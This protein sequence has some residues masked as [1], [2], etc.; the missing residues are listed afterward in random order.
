MNNTVLNKNSKTLSCITFKVN[1]L[2]SKFNRKIQT[3]TI[4]KSN[5][6][7]KLDKD[8]A[9]MLNDL[10]TLSSCP[11][12]IINK[13]KQYGGDDFNKLIEFNE[14]LNELWA[15]VNS[16]E[17]LF[18]HIN[19]NINVKNTIIKK[20][21]GILEKHEYILLDLASKS[22]NSKVYGEETFNIYDIDKDG[23]ITQSEFNK[24]KTY[25]QIN[26]NNDDKIS[27]DEFKK[28]K[29]VISNIGEEYMKLKDNKTY[30]ITDLVILEKL[31]MICHNNFREI[32][33]L[34]EKINKDNLDEVYEQCLSHIKT[35]K[36]L[37]YTFNIKRSISTPKNNKNTNE[38]DE[39]EEELRNFKEMPQEESYISSLFE[40]NEDAEYGGY[41]EDGEDKKE[42]AI[43]SIECP[44]LCK[45]ESMVSSCLDVLN[46][47]KHKTVLHQLISDYNRV[48]KPYK[49]KLAN[50]S[51]K[52]VDIRHNFSVFLTTHGI[53]S[54]EELPYTFDKSIDYYGDVKKIF[55][56]VHS[57]NEFNNF[58]KMYNGILEKLK[59][60][61]NPSINV[62]IK[63]YDINKELYMDIDNN[64]DPIMYKEIIELKSKYSNSKEAK[65]HLK[66]I[67]H[68]ILRYWCLIGIGEMLF[69]SEYEELLE[70]LDKLKEKLKDPYERMELEIGKYKNGYMVDNLIGLGFTNPIN[71]NKPSLD[72]FSSSVLENIDISKVEEQL[73]E[74]NKRIQEELPSISIDK[75]KC[76]SKGGGLNNMNILDMNTSN[77]NTS[78]MNTF[79]MNTHDMNTV[80]MNRFEISSMYREHNTSNILYRSFYD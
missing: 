54:I 28:Y 43:K 10:D 53:D 18:T 55:D 67:K 7:K 24:V 77:M 32:V 27:M 15:L 25:N 34:L 64:E 31:R 72:V 26:T 33:T 39:E 14:M 57:L 51:E 73:D 47:L 23:C 49:D 66:N 6:F 21:K 59:L 8:L 12:L 11:E 3:N 63:Q 35:I 76:M 9:Y 75:I 30:D 48:L 20:I 56:I 5:T 29:G 19:Y 80:D 41:G 38:L 45:E 69:T 44:L 68:N 16:T 13:N 52:Q 61:I 4:K 58:K 60:K 36:D 62:Y 70:Q 71:Y 46:A 42:D 74:I 22:E 50:L 79:D 78:N 65:T 40:D 37:L 17:N 2:L 1:N